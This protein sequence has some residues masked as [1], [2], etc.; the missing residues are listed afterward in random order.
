MPD[1]PSRGEIWLASL[2]SARPGEPGKTRPVLVLTPD[3]I[4]TTSDRD[5]VA[6]VPISSSV[7]A[8][9]LNPV[10]RA[11]SGL[12]QKSVAVV[13]SVRSLARARLLKQLGNVSRREQF[14]VDQALMVS[15]GLVRTD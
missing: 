11:G 12:E 7:P 4:L 9:R 13:R 3:A 2:G 6:V 10:L 8:T 5:L 1:L 14:E 15:L